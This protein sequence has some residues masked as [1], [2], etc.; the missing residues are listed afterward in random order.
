[1][2][3]SSITV[4][5]ATL[6]SLALIG[7]GGNSSSKSSPQSPTPTPASVAVKVAA[8][9]SSVYATGTD[10]FTATVT[11][12]SNT[13]VTWSVKEGSPGG[14][15]SASGLYKAPATA[16]TYHVIATSQADTSA[17]S[18][19]YPV[20]VTMPAVTFSTTPTTTLAEGAA[21]TYSIE[22]S[23]TAGTA[24]TYS[25]T[26][27]PAGASI[28]GSTVAWTPTAAELLMPSSFAIKATDAA[29]ASNTQSWTVT[30]K[31]AITMTLIDTFWAKS[32]SSPAPLT[33]TTP[34]GAL[35]PGSSTLIA[36][37]DNGDGTY[38]IHNVPAGYYWLVAGST[39]HYYTNTST[40]DISTDYV[41]QQIDGNAAAMPVTFGSAGPPA[42]GLTI[43]AFSDGEAIWVGSANENSWW[44]P[45]TQPA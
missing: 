32:G 11:G 4:I 37:V 25:L 15:I 1:M 8:A 12:N 2:R 10:Q 20:T 30:P 13:A 6:L 42:V 35:V 45:A 31:R 22:T 14:T 34:V 43:D 17:Q 24:I 16:G 38:T 5:A 18:S 33:G 29:G 40:F 23:D 41:G 28:S 44:A 26:S 21:Y 19:A 9:S 39:E 7:C 27:G 3:T 36:G